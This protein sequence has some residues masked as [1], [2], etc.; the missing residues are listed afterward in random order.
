MPLKL[1]ANN[2]APYN[3][4]TIPTNKS[5]AATTAFVLGDRVAPGNG[6]VYGCIAAGT[7]G[8]SAPTWP[9]TTDATVTDG[10]VTWRCECATNNPLSISATLTGAGGTVDS[11]T[12][13]CYLIARTYNYT[14]IGMALVNEDSAK[15]N[16]KLSINN[17]TWADILNSTDLPAMNATSADQTKTVY[18]KGIVTNDG[19]ANQPTTGTYTTPDIQIT[20]TENPT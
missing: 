7:S 10:T 18:V 20:A 3:Y 2:A 12:I 17:T 11:N 4:Y 15:I 14:G 8:G 19:S 1:S 16:W 6:Y 9:T 5:Y 13:T